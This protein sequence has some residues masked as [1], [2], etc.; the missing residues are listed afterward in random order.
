MRRVVLL[1][2][3]VGTTFAGVAG[4]ALGASTVSL[5]VPTVEGAAITTPSKGSCGSATSVEL[6]AEAKEQKK[7]ISILPHINYE[8]AGIGGKPTVQFTAI[9]L[10]VINGSGSE[11]TVNTAEGIA[12]SVTDGAHNLAFGKDSSVVGGE[13]DDATGPYSAVLG[14]HEVALSSEYGVSS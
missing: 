11:A 8:E 6:P 14:G 9:D 3:A 12:G 13:V 10:R 5:C 2:A 1:L 4:S 7:L